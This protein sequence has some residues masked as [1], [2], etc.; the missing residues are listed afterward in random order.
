MYITVTCISSD[1]LGEYI[2]NWRARYYILRA[3]GVF[4]GFKSK[5][6]AQTSAE[7]QNDFMLQG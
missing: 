1:F 2:R 4:H 3:D 5:E 7:I 6:E